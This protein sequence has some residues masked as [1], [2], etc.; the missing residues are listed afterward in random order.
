MPQAGEIRRGSTEAV[1]WDGSRWQPL[2]AAA[3]TSV[4]HPRSFGWLD[5]VPGL[6]DVLNLPENLVKGAQALPDVARGLVHEPGATL[7]GFAQGSSEAATPGRIGL[8]SLL[9]AGATAPAALAAAGGEALAQGTRV[10][11]DAPNAP[12]SFPE[13]AGNVV[14]AAAVPGL[15]GALKAVP[16]GVE[17]LGGT[18]KVAGGLIGAGLGGYEGYRYGGVPGALAGAVAGGTLGG[19]SPSMRA[20]RSVLGSGAEAETV[21]DVAPA[22]VE[23]FKPNRSGIPAS[24]EVPGFSMPKETQGAPPTTDLPRSVLSEVDRYAPNVSGYDSQGP[25]GIQTSRIPYGSGSSSTSRSMQGLKKATGF[26]DAER[27]QL[28]LQRMTPESIDRFEEDLRR[29]GKFR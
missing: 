22:G 3:P 18:R 20:L 5:A 7:K 17:R 2:A 23:R 8:L 1:Q 28:A 11:T 25:S 27:E 10:A 26:S 9:T 21:S 24:K 6:R 12:Q 29:A 14:E 13:A 16:A 15:A 19:G 4:D